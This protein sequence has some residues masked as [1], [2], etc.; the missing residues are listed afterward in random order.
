MKVTNG[1]LESNKKAKAVNREQ[2]LQLGIASVIGKF[3]VFV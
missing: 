3:H 2:V 1:W